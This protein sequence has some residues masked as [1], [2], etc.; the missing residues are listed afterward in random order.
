MEILGEIII[1]F[2]NDN[3]QFYLEISGRYPGFPFR[4]SIV[5]KMCNFS[6]K[7]NSYL[8]PLQDLLFK[9]CIHLFCP[10]L[11]ITKS[12][13]EHTVYCFNNLFMYLAASQQFFVWKTLSLVFHY[14]LLSGNS[15]FLNFAFTCKL[16]RLEVHLS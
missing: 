12:I 16:R 8:L 2:S 15:F 9:T 14:N 5:I 6:L 7:P 11:P 3:F 1:Y 13:R 10:M 4:F